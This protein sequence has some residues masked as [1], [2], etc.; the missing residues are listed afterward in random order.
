MGKVL[1]PIVKEFE[2]QARENLCTAAFTKT[3]SECNAILEK[4]CDYLDVLN[5]R[6]IIQQ[7][8]LACQSKALAHI[9]QRELYTMGNSI[10]IRCEAEMTHLQPHLGDSR[11]QELRNSPFWPTPLFRSQLV[12]DGEKFLLKKGSPKNT[13]SFDPIKT[14]PFVVPTTIRKEAPTGNVPMGDS[15]LQTI[16]NCFSQAGGN[17]VTEAPGVV[18]NLTQGDKGVE[19]PPHNDS[20]K[21]SLRPS[22]EGRLHSFRRHWPTKKCSNNVFNI[23][24]NIANVGYVLPFIRK[25]KSARVPLIHSDYKAHQR[26]LALASSI[27]SLLLKNAIERVENVKSLRFYSR[28]FLIPKLY[29]RWRPVIYLSRLNTFLLV[30]RFKMEMPEPIRASLIPGE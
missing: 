5:K 10:L 25:P 22:V 15:P 17:R 7:R 2:H 1:L 13:Q 8:A 18:F 27:Q 30:E 16:T 24:A 6:I 12:N 28:L 19:T 4:T 21:V 11:C 23:I 14:S 20:F 3:A 26:D 9:L 29:Q